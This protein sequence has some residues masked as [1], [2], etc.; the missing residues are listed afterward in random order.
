MNLNF[1]EI[2]AGILCLIGT[3]SLLG[4]L[5]YIWSNTT[6]EGHTANLE[7]RMNAKETCSEERMN[8][9]LQTHQREVEGIVPAIAGMTVFSLGSVF[10]MTSNN[11]LPSAPKAPKPYIR[12]TA[13]R[14]QKQR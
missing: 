4:A 13:L 11:P 3:A 8:L 7:C 14:R 2:V 1:K 6:P 5:G 9:A 10:G 12:P